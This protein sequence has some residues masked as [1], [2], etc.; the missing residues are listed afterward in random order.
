MYAFSCEMEEDSSLLAEIKTKQPKRIHLSSD[1]EG[2][3]NY[4]LVKVQLKVQKDKLEL[5]YDADFS[6]S[7]CINGVVIWLCALS[8]TKFIVPCFDSKK[9]LL[10][11]DWTVTKQV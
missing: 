11:D 7:L 3:D 2:Y 4:W 5:K 8:E 10:I 9:V 1:I 6:N